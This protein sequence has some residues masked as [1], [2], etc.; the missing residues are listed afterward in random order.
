MNFTKKMFSVLLSCIIAFTLILGAIQPI[1]SQAISLLPDVNYGDVD[2]NGEINMDD[3]IMLLRHVSRA[4]EITDE[5]SLAAGE[6]I[7]DDE[8]NMDDVIRL[9]RYVSRSTDVLKDPKPNGT[10]NSVDIYSVTNLII[11]EEEN[12]AIANISAPENCALLVR[13]IDEEVYFSEDYPENKYYIDEYDLYASH[14]VRGGTDMEDV[15]AEI[16]GTLPE[17]Y[18]AEAILVDGNGEALCQPTTYIENTYRYEQYENKTVNDFEE[19]DT[20]LNFDEEID[21]NFGVLADDVIIL[22]V[23]DLVVEEETNIHYLTGVTTDLAIG[24]KVFINDGIDTALIRISNFVISDSFIE[25]VPA[26]ADDE[27]LGFGLFD[28]YKYLKVDTD[29]NGEMTSQDPSEEALSEYAVMPMLDIIDVDH[30]KSAS[31]TVNPITFE[32]NRFRASGNIGGKIT[33]NIVMQYDAKLFSKDYIKCNFTVDTDLSANLSVV[34]KWGTQEEDPEY[35]SKEIKLGKIRIPFGVTGLSAFT[36]IKAEVKW[37]ITA[38]LEVTGTIKTT[39]GFKYNTKDGYTKVDKKNNNWSVDLRGKGEISFGPSPSIGVQFLEGVVKADLE[40]FFGVKAEG[41]AVIPVFQ[42]GDSKHACHLCVKGE[43]K[44][45]ISV[46]AKLSYHVTKHLKGTPI[47]INLVTLE[48]KIFDFFVSILNDRDSKYKGQLTFGIGSCENE[49]FK[50]TFLTYDSEEQ[51]IETT[52]TITDKETGNLIGTVTSGDHL[53][54]YDG[55]YTASATIEDNNVSKTFTVSEEAQTVKITANTRDG[56]ITGVIRNAEDASGISGASVSVYKGDVY[57]GGTSTDSD[58][59]YT[60]SLAEGSY[61]Y[62]IAA[63]GFVSTS[64]YITIE[65]GETKYMEATLMAEDDEDS[66][67]GG[68]YGTITDAKTGY[69]LSGVKVQIFEGMNNTTGT[70]AAT[71][72]VVNTN[73]SGEYSYRSWK[74]F[75]ITYGLPAGNYTI[76]LSKEGYITTSFNIV[77]VGGE[78]IQFNGSISPETDENEFRIVLTW[79]STPRDLDSHYRTSNEHVYYSNKWENSA[80]LDV[81]DTSSYGPETVTVTNFSSLE[82]GFVY[83]VH[84]YT[85]KYDSSS[86]AMSNSGAKIQVYKGGH[87][88]ATYHVPVGVAGTVWNVFKVTAEGRIIPIN[89]MTHQES[90]GSVGSGLISASTYSFRE[91]VVENVVDE[92]KDYELAEQN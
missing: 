16:I 81:D 46:D 14:V 85:N 67:M 13:F 55:N 80:N 60:M 6:I 22:N 69:A 62:V 71:D 83:C 2:L 86:T 26:Q 1:E 38:G 25:I 88:I 36:E 39:N 87:L 28:F 31:I 66:I 10:Q 61:K 44:G 43:V 76:V 41:E 12:L 75:G 74:V 82:N 73:S 4:E 35:E 30:S 33:A 20:V 32:T 27:E 3:V 77:V 23:Y 40:C 78:D 52:I 54:L 8:L 64:G 24:D 57:Y 89:T 37:E 53:Y 51:E 92:L 45:V 58:G 70:S 65:D 79:G 63:E 91:P 90:P 7:E 18:V 42:G 49:S 21:D 48:K 50:T 72:I 11:N 5:Y 59:S 68:V 15:T 17:Y 34:A 9:L 19:N 56:E 29:Y 84:D 47:D